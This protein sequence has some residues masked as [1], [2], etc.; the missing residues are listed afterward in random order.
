MKKTLIIKLKKRKGEM[1]KVEYS[2]L[3][4]F[5]I[6]K[7]AFIKSW[8][9]EMGRYWEGERI[10]TARLIYILLS[11]SLNFYIHISAISLSNF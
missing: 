6:G 1:H 4:G 9:R 3:F 8:T 2:Y 10:I 7:T 5:S 11:L